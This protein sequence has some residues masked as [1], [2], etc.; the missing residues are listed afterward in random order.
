MAH[1][2]GELRAI[3]VVS[4]SVVLADW[5]F[6]TPAV[7]L[8]PV[9][10]VWLASSAGIP[11]TSGW[12][13]LAICLYVLTGVCWVPVVWLQIR[14]HQLAAQTLASGCELPPLYFS[15]SRLWFML[16]WPAFISVVGIF[17]LMV[18]KPHL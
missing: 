8:Q 17:Y 4:R 13:F 6:T 1:R 2:T 10:G 7:V 18:F 11:L 14:M 3:V 9:S 12:L 5:F 15:Y 16:G